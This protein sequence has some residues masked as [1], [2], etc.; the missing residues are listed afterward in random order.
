[1]EARE[2]EKVFIA[3]RPQDFA[4]VEEAEILGKTGAKKTKYEERS[5]EAAQG[6]YCS[7]HPWRSAY[8]ICAECHRPFCYED[9]AEHNG[10]YYCLEDIDKVAAG[11]AEETGAGYNKVSVI[12]A[13]AFILTIAVYL[14]FT[15]GQL[16]YIATYANQVG[17]GAFLSNFNYSYAVAIGGTLFT[18]MEFLSSLLL[19]G[20]SKKGYGLGMLSGFL[21]I[22][23][24]AYEFIS[25]YAIYTAIIAVLSFIGLIAL[26]YSRNAYEPLETSE[27]SIVQEMSPYDWP[28]VGRF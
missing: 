9:L 8:A 11:K 15:N 14:Y 20:Q 7:W 3:P 27:S 25:S 1:M 23:L 28:N 4:Q 19:F 17:F 10:R 13:S 22:A 18:F 26:G 6:L 5:R 21:S 2:E 16:I 24:F 12:S